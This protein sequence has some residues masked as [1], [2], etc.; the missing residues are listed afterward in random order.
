[1]KCIYIIIYT[2]LPTTYYPQILDN[3]Q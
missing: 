1:M 3:S 2:I